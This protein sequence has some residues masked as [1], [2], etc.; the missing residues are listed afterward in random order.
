MLGLAPKYRIPSV[1]SRCGTAS[2]HSGDSCLQA[3][4]P[5]S[6]A[7]PTVEL[8][9]WRE[10]TCSCWQEEGSSIAA[11]FG[12]L[13]AKDGGIS[14]LASKQRQT[15]RAAMDGREEGTDRDG[16]GWGRREEGLRAESGLLR[17]RAA[18]RYLRT[19]QVPCTSPRGR[20]RG[21][22]YLPLP[23]RRYEYYRRPPPVRLC[24]SAITAPTAPHRMDGS[25]SGQ[26]QRRVPSSSW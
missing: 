8:A 6:S 14:P 16:R 5:A 3:C 11:A 15:T 25:H 22:M 12:P 10:E 26:F 21:A 19:A 4:T 7:R 1:S 24:R 23:R 18:L 9:P 20:V 2:H 17:R 13:R